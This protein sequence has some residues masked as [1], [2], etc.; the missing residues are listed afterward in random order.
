MP[1]PIC[2]A[3]ERGYDMRLGVEP[4][5]LVAWLYAGPEGADKECSGDPTRASVRAAVAH[6]LEEA[7]GAGALASSCEM[8][9][10][11]HAEGIEAHRVSFAYEDP[12]GRTLAR[13]VLHAVDLSVAPGSITLVAAVRDRVSQRCFRSWAGLEE[14]RE[15]IV[16]VGR[17]S[18]LPGRRCGGV[19]EP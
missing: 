4:G 19:P 17:G 9:E 13:E 1:R 11:A 8:R 5:D 7:G 6:I 18:R 14:P 12:R 2:T 15:G 10:H 3:V 16:T